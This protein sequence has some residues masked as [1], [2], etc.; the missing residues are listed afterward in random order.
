MQ[1]LGTYFFGIL[2]GMGAV[3]SFLVHEGFFVF[4]AMGLIG[5]KLSERT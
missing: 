5:Y 2:T 1:K 3:L 4:I